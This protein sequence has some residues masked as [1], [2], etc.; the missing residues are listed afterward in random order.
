LKITGL[1]EDVLFGR[2]SIRLAVIKR[3]EVPEK[4]AGKG[5]VEAPKLQLNVVPT[6]D[7]LANIVF[8][9]LR[10]LR[11]RLADEQGYP[12]YII[13]SDKVLHLIAAI[14]PK[15]VEEFGNIS[16]IGEFKQ[17][18]YGRLFVDEILKSIQ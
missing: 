3:E 1:G 13:M 17:R 9:R 7:A 18:K 2:S 16:G 14:R 8:E 6:E 5:K 11:R 12:P 4:K 15:T 10:E